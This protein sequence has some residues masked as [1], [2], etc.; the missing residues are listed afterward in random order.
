WPLTPRWRPGVLAAGSIAALGLL[1]RQR[2]GRLTLFAGL[3]GTLQ[4]LCLGSGG[5]LPHPLPPAPQAS[6]LGRGFGRRRQCTRGN[7][8]RNGWR[9][10]DGRRQFLGRRNE[11]L[12]PWHADKER[13]PVAVDEVLLHRREAGRDA[14]VEGQPCWEC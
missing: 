10:R 3:L 14:P 2:T 12:H 13:T 4:R 1:L 6:F 8:A 11:V 7:T 5:A 9:T